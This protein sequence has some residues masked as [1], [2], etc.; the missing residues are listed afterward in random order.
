VTVQKYMAVTVPEAV[1]P[2]IVVLFQVLYQACICKEHIGTH[3]NVPVLI[4]SLYAGHLNSVFDWH[5]IL[6]D[7]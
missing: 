2:S 6:K 4:F 5:V 3:K 1:Y 7:L